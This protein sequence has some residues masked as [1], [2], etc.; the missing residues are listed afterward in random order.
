MVS[1]IGFGD[2]FY[3]ANKFVICLASL[4]QC[5][6]INDGQVGKVGFIQFFADTF[7]RIGISLRKRE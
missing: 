3:L 5:C 7:E 4:R 1:Q 6:E 2:I